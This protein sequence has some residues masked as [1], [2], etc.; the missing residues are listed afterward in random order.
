MP[1]LKFE[2]KE[3]LSRADAAARLS[4]IADALGSDDK[5]ELERAGE[6]LELRVPDEVRFE[7][8]VEIKDDETEL[9]VEIKWSTATEGPA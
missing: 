8:E 9:E 1:E 4:A 5:S 6:K 3:T 2:Q 7:W